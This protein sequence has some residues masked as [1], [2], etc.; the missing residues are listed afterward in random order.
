MSNTTERP[1]QMTESNLWVT[2]MGSLVTLGESY[3]WRS[4]NKSVIAMGSR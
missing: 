1:N 4:G 3:Q 2:N